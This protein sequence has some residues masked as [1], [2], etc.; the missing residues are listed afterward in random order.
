[1]GK[2]SLKTSQRVKN[3]D[4]YK[5]P[6]GQNLQIFSFSSFRIIYIFVRCVRACVCV[7]VCVCVRAVGRGFQHLPSDLA[8]VN[9]LEN[10]V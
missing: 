8:N 7:C 2:T 4:P 5:H 10:N 9:V 6:M 1:M 3:V